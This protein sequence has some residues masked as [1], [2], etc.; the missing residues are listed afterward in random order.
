MMV[1]IKR[2]SRKQGKYYP[3]VILPSD[4]Q[5]W[6]LHEPPS[7]REA[8]LLPAVGWS[9]LCGHEFGLGDHMRIDSIECQARNS[10]D[11]SFARNKMSC[12]CKRAASA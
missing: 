10:F 3:F 11:D 9:F 8:K 1:R 4:D 7:K 5:S 2:P 12:A 6:S